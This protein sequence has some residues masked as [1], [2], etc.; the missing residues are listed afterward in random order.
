MKIINFIFEKSPSIPLKMAAMPA[1][2]V[3]DNP[4][5]KEA[6]YIFLVKLIG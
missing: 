1:N 2:R 4:P 6:R 3:R 5:N